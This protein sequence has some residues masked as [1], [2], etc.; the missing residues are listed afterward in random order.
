MIGATLLTAA[1]DGFAPALFPMVVA[2]L[3][4]GAGAFILI[5][6]PARLRSVVLSTPRHSRVTMNNVAPPGPPSMQAKQPSSDST[7]WSI[8]P[9]SRTRTQRLLGTSAY[10]TASWASMQMPSGTPFRKSAHVLRFDR[11]PSAAMSNAVSFFPYDSATISVE[12][13]G[14]TAMPFANAKP[15]ATGRTEPSD[16]LNDHSG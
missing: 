5:T 3:A 8:S 2:F 14:V 15:S 9:P 4:S 11:C 10:Q 6:R 7:V 13:S 16:N 1:A 12:L